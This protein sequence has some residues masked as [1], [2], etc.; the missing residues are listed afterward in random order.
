MEGA[1]CLTTVNAQ[2]QMISDAIH[3]NGFFRPRRNEDVLGA[4]PQNLVV[5]EHVLPRTSL[6]Q[7]CKA[8]VV[9]P[10]VLIDPSAQPRVESP[11]LAIIP[12]AKG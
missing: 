4:S 10:E 3:L 5:R 11:E 12:A 2:Q 7:I 9:G 6:Y 1:I 8:V